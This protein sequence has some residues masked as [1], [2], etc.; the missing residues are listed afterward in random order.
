MSLLLKLNDYSVTLRVV[1][2]FH[3]WFRLIAP[4]PHLPGTLAD[5]ALPQNVYLQC[6]YADSLHP[7]TLLSIWLLLTN[8]AA[9]NVS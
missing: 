1:R 3:R 7:V 6:H 5:I 2:L 9:L 8:N 4:A